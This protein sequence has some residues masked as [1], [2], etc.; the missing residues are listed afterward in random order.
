[1]GRR[2]SSQ[3]TVRTYAGQLKWLSGWAIRNGNTLLSDLT[4]GLLRRAMTARMVD[5]AEQSTNY[6]GGEAA[7]HNMGHAARSLVRWL[8][9][10]GIAAP[11]LETVRPPRVPERV[12]PRLRADEFQALEST[13]LHR[14]VDS[15]GRR[16]T[17]V[18]VVRDLALIYFLA[19][20]GLR[21]SEVC[22][23]N[24]KSIDFE[25]GCVH[26]VR[27]KG[28]KERVLSLVDPSD[29][30]GGTTIGLLH[31]W[32][33]ARATVRLN[34]RHQQLWTSIRGRPLSSHELRRVLAKLCQAAGIDSNRPPHAFRRSAFT[35]GYLANPSTVQV[36]AARMGWAP[37]SRHMIDVYTRGANIDLI[38]TTPVMAVSGRLR[39]GVRAPTWGDSRT[40]RPP[41]PQ[42]PT[43][44]MSARRWE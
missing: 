32:M 11:D 10:Q 21:A 42:P 7:A 17:R 28:N 41:A 8:A 38:A 1:M 34:T 37:K 25:R 4:P 16:M 2:G 5:A 29:P 30:D 31:D 40:A 23:L 33:E 15:S 6:R 39:E 14:L 18:A 44:R 27:G 12:Q 26:V 36:L 13:I 9:T 19:D 43:R 35:E 3:N 24:L 20:T 22:S